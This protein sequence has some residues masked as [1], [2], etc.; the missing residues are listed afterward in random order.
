MYTSYFLHGIYL[1]RSLPSE[2]LSLTAYP[3]HAFSAALLGLGFRF[4]PRR[5]NCVLPDLIVLERLIHQDACPLLVLSPVRESSEMPTKV[6]T[7]L[8][9]P[10][11]WRKFAETLFSLS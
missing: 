5:Q 6:A 7:V 8:R 2:P 9:G 4:H 11:T 1:I 10:S 3:A